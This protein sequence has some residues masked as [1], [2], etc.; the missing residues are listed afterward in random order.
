MRDFWRF[1]PNLT[2]HAWFL[3]LSLSNLQSGRPSFVPPWIQ[4]SFF[5]LGLSVWMLHM[6]ISLSFNFLM[7]FILK[8]LEFSAKLKFGLAST[9]VDEQYIL[10]TNNIYR[11]RKSHLQLI[12]TTSEHLSNWHPQTST[13]LL[14]VIWLDINIDLTENNS[15]TACSL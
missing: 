9:L 12:S 11:L 7:Y 13:H 15:S 14:Y 6:I 5:W 2:H 1:R 3:C 10:H 4:P 8:W